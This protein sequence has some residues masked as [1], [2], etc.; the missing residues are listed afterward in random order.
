MVLKNEYYACMGIRYRNRDIRIMGRHSAWLYIKASSGNNC[1]PKCCR[2]DIKRDDHYFLRLFPSGLADPALSAQSR[3]K[4]RPNERG[5]GQIWHPRT[6]L[7]VTAPCRG[8]ARCCN[9]DFVRRR[10]PQT[11]YLDDDRHHLLERRTYGR[12]C[13]WSQCF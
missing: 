2:V 6:R 10:T 1:D 3:R 5:M 8:T 13:T 7:F 9:W 4:R 12:C 11:V